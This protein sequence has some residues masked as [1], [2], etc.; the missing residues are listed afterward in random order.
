VAFVDA[1]SGQIKRRVPV[2][3]EPTGVAPGQQG[4]RL[5]VTCAGTQSS[6]LVVG[7]ASGEVE[8]RIPAGHTALAPVVGPHGKRLYVCNRFSNSVSV[9]DLA[10]GREVARVP[11]TREPFAAALTPDGT[12]LLVANHLPADRADGCE[13]AA[14]VTVMDTHTHQTETIRPPDG[15]CSLCGICVSPEG[16]Y[17]YVTHLLARYELPTTQVDYGW[18]NANALTVIDTAHN[19]RLNTVLLDDMH[20]GAANPWGVRCTADGKWL[21]VSH[22]GSH[23][24]S[25]ID[26]PAL[27]K[28]L[29][30]VPV[31][32][33]PGQ[34]GA[35]IYDDRN[36]ILDCVREIRAELAGGK[37]PCG[38][39]RR[40][41]YMLGDAAGV[42]ND[43][44]F[45]EGLR[46]RI[47]LDGKG[48]RGLAIAGARVYVAEHFT[49][50]L[51]VVDLAAE[52]GEQV[53]TV[54]LGLSPRLTARRRGEMLFHDATL[55]LEHWQ[56]CASCHP[57]GRADGLNWDLLNDGMANLKNTKS[58]L[59]AHKTPPAMSTAVRPSAEAAVRAGIRHILFGRLADNDALAIDTYLKSLRAVASPHLV[60]GRLSPAARR[61]RKLF[62][63][64]RIGCA[65]CHPPPLYTDLRLHDVGTKSPWDSRCE[66]D[67]PTLIEVWRTAPYLHDG[68]YTAIKELIAE[69]QHG[70]ERGAVE[71]LTEQQISDLVEFML[72]L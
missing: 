56:C 31:D 20:E 64:E 65:A 5:Y 22:A 21:C 69:G 35:V 26:A 33:P 72:S 10:A 71:K 17:A 67:T 15:A 13:V 40:R 48:P 68:R 43:L 34:I 36:E 25:V 8:A 4:K 18:M 7:A 3:Q 66:F 39:G 32:P 50:T 6:V 47:K 27:V 60:N 49:D 61:G 45:L 62:L 23:E 63:S 58:L 11:T 59:L 51:S 70:K 46:R 52:P 9:I 55:C 2:S 16:G 29:L 57:G 38:R 24:L 14:V 28:K 44:T 30:A 19:K 41:L 12:S 1:R 42:S 37:R 53:R 54:P